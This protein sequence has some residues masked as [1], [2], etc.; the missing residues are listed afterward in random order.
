M[1]NN[2]A[3]IDVYLSI[4]LIPK[5][6]LSQRNSLLSWLNNFFASSILLSMVG[7]EINDSIDAMSRR[8][9]VS[10]I[11]EGSGAIKPKSTRVRIKALESGKPG[12]GSIYRLAI[13]SSSWSTF[14]AWICVI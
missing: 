11:N 9:N 4:T 1:D 7:A 6:N 8:Q 5:I 12:K 14:S 3:D 2:F 10:P 13:H